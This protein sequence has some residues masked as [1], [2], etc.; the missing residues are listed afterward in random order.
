MKFWRQKCTF[1]WKT[2]AQNDDEIDIWLIYISI[3]D[4]W[5]IYI[6]IRQFYE[7][8]RPTSNLA[9]K[10]AKLREKIAQ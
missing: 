3:S 10:L 1:I 9:K 2:R 7:F 6:P 5:L 4:I 8:F